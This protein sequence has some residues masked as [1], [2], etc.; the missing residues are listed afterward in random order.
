MSKLS[1]LDKNAYLTIYLNQGVISANLAYSHYEIGRSY[2]LNDVSQYDQYREEISTVFFWDEYFGALEKLWNW[3]LITP[4]E[5]YQ[6]FRSTI[7]FTDEGTGVVM[8]KVIIWNHLKNLPEIISSL[9]A[10]SPKI[11]IELVD[12]KK[13]SERI[14]TTADRL[15]YSDVLHLDLNPRDFRYS[16]MQKM[17]NK[18]RMTNIKSPLWNFKHAKLNWDSIDSLINLFDSSKFKAF[19]SVDVRDALKSTWANFIVKPTLKIVEGEMLDF[20]RAFVTAQLFSS[21]NDRSE[22]FRE[23][24]TSDLA[25]RLNEEELRDFSHSRLIIVSGSVARIL[26]PKYL[27]LSILDGLQV[28]G[29]VDVFIDYDDRFTSFGDQYSL[30]VNATDYIMTRDELGFRPYRVY[31]PEIPGGGNESKV[32][33]DGQNIITTMSKD[34]ENKNAQIQSVYALSGQIYLYKLPEAEKNYISGKFVRGAYVDGIGE[35]LLLVSESSMIRYDSL[36][37]DARFK[38]TVYGPNSATNRNNLSKWLS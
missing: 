37:I 4:R 17:N 9:R 10:V 7:P 30:G 13:V 19:L 29:G 1:L 24:G 21:Y 32:V 26:P 33:F 35:E 31:S 12:Q 38:P 2:V 36:I 8:I 18:S 22:I 16:R 28:R 23:I 15:G 34:G 27:I 3:E 20:M 5:V 6:T 14:S 25:Q 11:T